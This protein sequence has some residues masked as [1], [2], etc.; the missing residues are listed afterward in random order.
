MLPT[1]R[2]PSVL[3]VISVPSYFFFSHSPRLMEAVAWGI[4]LARAIIMETA[5]SAVVMVLPPGVFM[6]TMPF[7]VAATVSTLSTPVPALPMTLRFSAASIISAVALV[8]LL[9]TRP[10]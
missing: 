9:T 1:P 3:P 4:F 6:T 8:A 5:C 7:F 10:W 2:M